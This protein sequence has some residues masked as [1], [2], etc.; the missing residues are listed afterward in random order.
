MPHGISG[1][2]ASAV[3]DTW[4]AWFCF[5]A[6]HACLVVMRG[7]AGMLAR[8]ARKTSG[9]LACEAQRSRRARGVRGDVWRQD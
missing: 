6:K 4:R 5:A 1:M 7:T 3:R 8:A 9:T 2:L